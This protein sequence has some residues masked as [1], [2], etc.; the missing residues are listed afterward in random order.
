MQLLNKSSKTAAL[1][2][3]PASSEP[4]H[5]LI[6]N[7]LAGPLLSDPGLVHA[8]HAG[9]DH[10]L[11][12]AARERGVVKVW[13]ERAPVVPQELQSNGCSNARGDLARGEASCV[14]SPV[15]RRYFAA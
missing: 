2:S 6:A 9:E 14:A 4:G 1:H 10:A 3:N 12:G 15:R 13:K 11:A 7:Q 5:I 8:L